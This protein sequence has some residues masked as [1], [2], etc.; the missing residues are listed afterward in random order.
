MRREGVVTP[1]FIF[2]GSLLNFLFCVFAFLTFEFNK[3]AEPVDGKRFIGLIFPFVNCALNFKVELL[4]ILSGHLVFAVVCHVFLFYQVFPPFVDSK[5]KFFFSFT[6]VLEFLPL[7]LLFVRATKYSNNLPNF[8]SFRLIKRKN[9]WMFKSRRNAYQVWSKWVC[10]SVF[11]LKSQ[12]KY[13]FIALFSLRE[14]EEDFYSS[15]PSLPVSFVFNYI[16]NTRK[17]LRKPI[18]ALLAFIVS[19]KRWFSKNKVRMRTL[20]F[21]EKEK[22]QTFFRLFSSFPGENKMK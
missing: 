20:L 3:F 19:V 11:K 4:K 8:N 1:F 13:D 6:Y 2:F 21:S 5:K 9:S 14:L 10:F 7:S 17:S 18:A 22:W 15:F 16:L 12:L